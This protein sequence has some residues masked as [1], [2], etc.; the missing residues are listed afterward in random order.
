MEKTFQTHTDRHTHTHKSLLIYLQIESLLCFFSLVVLLVRTCL[1]FLFL[2]SKN[3]NKKGRESLCSN[4]WQ[5]VMKE[6]EE[7]GGRR[8]RGKDDSISFS[9]FPSV[10]RSVRVCP[11]SRDKTH[12]R[13]SEIESTIIGVAEPRDGLRWNDN[14]KKK[15]KPN[16]IHNEAA[17]GVGGDRLA[18]LCTRLCVCVCACVGTR[19]E[20]GKS[21]E[22]EKV[23]S[24]TAVKTMQHETVQRGRQRDR[25]TAT[26]VPYIKRQ[27]IP[28]LFVGQKK[29]TYIYIYTPKNCFVSEFSF[30]LFDSVKR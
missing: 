24:G 13:V 14:G 19:N 12:N 15:K 10:L 7:G 4:K 9:R 18:C 28:L 11:C 30:F 26:H 1:I 25:Q 5:C 3:K 16:V 8:G 22:R 20:K 21:Q 2:F 27:S 6:E 17:R 23:K 29:G